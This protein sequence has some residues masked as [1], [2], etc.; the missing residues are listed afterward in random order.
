MVLDDPDAAAEA[1]AVR[2]DLSGLARA[3]DL[4]NGLIGLAE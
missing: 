2:L 3:E 4:Y 1:G